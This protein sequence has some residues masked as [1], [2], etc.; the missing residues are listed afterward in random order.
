ML[1]PSRAEVDAQASNLEPPDT[2]TLPT[3]DQKDARALVRQLADYES[4]MYPDLDAKLAAVS[5]YE[6]QQIL[7]ALK[8]VN[9]LDQD[10]DTLQIQG[11]LTS[12]EDNDRTGWAQFIR[13]VL[14]DGTL[15]P[16]TVAVGAISDRYSAGW[17]GTCGCLR[18]S[19]GCGGVCYGG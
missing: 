10:M 19:C 2:G 15:A 4:L 17:C 12:K 7:A 9:D 5:G 16:E 1:K 3:A 14:F 8:R 6:A 13:S 11:L 18:A